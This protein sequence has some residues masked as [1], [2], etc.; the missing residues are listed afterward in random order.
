MRILKIVKLFIEKGNLSKDDI[1]E[2]NNG[3]ATSIHSTSHD[4]HFEVIELLITMRT[5]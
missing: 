5:C 1:M 4:R 2:K 3:G